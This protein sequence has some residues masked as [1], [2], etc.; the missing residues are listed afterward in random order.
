MRSGWESTRRP[1]RDMSVLI[2][3]LDQVGV[4]KG[5]WTL[6]SELSLEPA[7]PMHSFRLRETRDHEQVH[8]RLLDSRWAE[9]AISYLR[10]QTEFAEKRNKLSRN[11]APHGTAQEEEEGQSRTRA[12]PKAQP[13]K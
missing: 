2:L 5:G 4:D 13:K 12:K 3:M 9:L 1:K 8:S 6:A 11:R 7:I 10:E